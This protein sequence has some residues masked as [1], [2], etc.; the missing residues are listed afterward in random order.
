MPRAERQVP[1]V[2]FG[3][4]GALVTLPY[5]RS[6][7]DRSYDRQ[8]FDF[9]SGAGQHMVSSLAQGSRAYAVN[10]TNL[11]LDT[12][13]LIDQYWA[14]QMGVG[15]W[16]F[17]DPSMPNMLL[18]NQASA[19]NTLYDTTGFATSTGAANMGTLVSSTAS[20]VLAQRAGSA[21][22]LRW[23]FPVAAAT[24]PILTLTNP[25]RNWYGFPAVPALPYTWSFYARPDGTVDTSITLAAKLQW[26]DAAG[27]QIGAD[28][29][30]GDIV[31]AAGFVQL[32]VTATAPA[33][34]AYVKPIWVATGSTITTGASIYID[35]PQLEQD[36]VVNSWAPGTGLRPVEI[37]GLND[38]VPFETRFRKSPTLQLRELAV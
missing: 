18:P 17:I 16:A 13:R 7:M 27:A 28:V 29:S 10:W 15:P 23:Q 14:N 22:N 5:P 2:Y 36:S 32:S 9:V 11:H 24:T 30:G 37:L 20:G 26:F 21:R 25:Y 3:R 4:P 35:S 19:T 34:T 8:V 6:D 1:S 31:M 33:G 12:Y 38:S